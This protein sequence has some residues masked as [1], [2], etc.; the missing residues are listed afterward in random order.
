M[1]ASRFE[2]RL[3]KGGVLGVSLLL[4]LAGCSKS[5]D[6][7]DQG[8]NP[9]G[10]GGMGGA[11]AGG[12]APT[13]G[14][15]A[16][17]GGTAAPTGGTA[18]P[19]A[20]NG[21]TAG[22]SGATPPGGA[23]GMDGAAGEP[24]G[25]GTG[26]DAAPNDFMHCVSGIAN[27][28]TEMQAGPCGSTT[29]RYGVDIEFGP[30]GARQEYNVGQGFE[31]PVASGDSDGGASCS[32]FVATFAAD[33][34]A[35]AELQM[36]M[37]LDFSLYTVFYPGVMPEGEKFPVITWGN[38]TC[39]M[40]EGYGGLLRYVASHGYIVVAA[41]SRWVGSNTGM[42]TAIDFIFAENEK[43]DSKYY[44][45]V[46]TTKVGAMGHSQGGMATATAA[47]DVRIQ[48]VILWNGGTSASKPFLAISGER[49]IFTTAASQLANPVN[50]APRPAA[51][52]F[53][54]DVP[55][56]VDGKTTGGSAG[57][58]TLM[59]EPERVVE[60]AVAWWDFQLKG[61][62]TAK[63]MFVGDSCGLCGG[64]AYPSKWVTPPSMPT[65]TYGHN[66]M[67]Q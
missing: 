35:S 52:L 12:A 6:P 59:Q 8:G 22:A 34:E 65:T 20:G 29:T 30:Y 7:N 9:V 54:H 47:S 44:Q 67:L 32:L 37:D 24:S 27:W 64:D 13:G 49:D 4:G 1:V 61:S 14:T 58:L 28:G 31:V 55:T 45:K 33:P 15:A 23:G 41:N 19:L 66:A 38:G 16:P 39:A 62:A 21:S 3:L 63:A 5:E 42:R 36:T 56:M 10:M 17:T 48:S 51:Y 26:G 53:Y 25:S 11:T 18:A 43:P 60:V 57:H 2:K 40:P 50:A 46:D